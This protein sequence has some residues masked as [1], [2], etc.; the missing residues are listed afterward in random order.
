VSETDKKKTTGKIDEDLVRN[1]ANLLIE[2]DISEIEIEQNGLRLRV[3]RQMTA[4]VAVAAAPIAAAA[5]APAS[6]APGEGSDYAS[7]PGAVTS[8]MVGTIYTSPDPESP[9]FV[10]EGDQVTEGQTVMIVEAMKTMNNIPAP[11]AGRVAKIL[12]SNEQPIEFG[13]VLIIIE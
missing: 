7:H 13:E 10:K 1:L 4:G 6:A 2:T 11:K 12:V 8:P 5:A 3:A 9:V